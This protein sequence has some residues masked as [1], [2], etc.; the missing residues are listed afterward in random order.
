MS[1]FP[2][3]FDPRDEIL[4]MIDLVALDTPDGTMRFM[5]GVD[6]LFT[7][8]SGNTWYGSQLAS[9]TGLQSAIGGVAPEGSITLSFFQ[10]PDADDLIAQIRELGA[11]YVR[12]RTITFYIQPIRSQAEFYAPSTSPLQWLQRTMKSLAFRASGAQD[13]SISVSF[14]TW[15]ENRRAARR[16]VLN[17]EGHAQLTGS[18]NPSLEYMPTVDFEEEKLFG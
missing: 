12:D 17:T 2:A 3:D 10:D 7:D 1:F 13:R 5:L 16:I 14:E 18:A 4:A 8:T 11:T 9:V 15:A 6:G